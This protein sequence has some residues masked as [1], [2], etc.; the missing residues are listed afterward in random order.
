MYLAG[1]GCYE[2]GELARAKKYIARPWPRALRGETHRQ[3][4]PRPPNNRLQAPGAWQE[5]RRRQPGCGVR[6][7]RGGLIAGGRCAV[8][9]GKGEGPC[10]DLPSPGH[11]R[12][13]ARRALPDARPGCALRCKGF[14]SEKKLRSSEIFS[15]ACRAASFLPTGSFF[16]G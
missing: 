16:P 1:R 2:A 4:V 13:Y 7:C 3:S 6:G 14:S 11:A 5:K 12:G 9:G 10:R 8:A 15:F